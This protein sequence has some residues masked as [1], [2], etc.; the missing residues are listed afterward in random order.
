MHSEDKRWPKDNNWYNRN[1][2]FALL[3]YSVHSPV[4]FSTNL[5]ANSVQLL[6]CIVVATPERLRQLARHQLLISIIII[7]PLRAP[8]FDRVAGYVLI[9]HFCIYANLHGQL[10]WM[11]IRFVCKSV[12]WFL[13]IP[14][15]GHWIHTHTHT[16][17]SPLSPQHRTMA[18]HSQPFGDNCCDWHWV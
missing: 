9:S 16:L 18:C 2:L 11:Q 15:R 6:N 1:A 12:K 8:S 10:K 4:A 17:H 5:L 3:A 13:P 14:H 7:I